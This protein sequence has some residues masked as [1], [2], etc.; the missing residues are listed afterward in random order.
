M[1]IFILWT[2][3]FEEYWL[4]KCFGMKVFPWDLYFRVIQ[5]GITNEEHF[6]EN[7]GGGSWALK[8]QD[9][10]L[11]KALTESLDTSAVSQEVCKLNVGFPKSLRL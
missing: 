1:L 9:G 8:A 10:L 2:L 3:Y 6:K 7:Q 11:Y 4:E 5:V